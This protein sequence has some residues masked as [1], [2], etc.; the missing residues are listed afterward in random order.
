MFKKAIKAL[1]KYLK[2]SAGPKGNLK[3]AKVTLEP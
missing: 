1:V 2:R 3:Q